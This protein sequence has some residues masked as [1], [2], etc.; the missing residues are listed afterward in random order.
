MTENTFALGSPVKIGRRVYHHYAIVSDRLHDGKPMLISL[1]YRTGSVA[2][3]P[4]DEVVRGRSVRRSDLTSKFDAGE[5]LARARARIGNTRYNLLKNNCE[6]FVRDVM[7]LPARSRQVE[8]AAGIGVTALL[9]ALRLAR[10]NPAIA[11]ASTAAG[12]LIG[13]RF[14]AK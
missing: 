6:H 11:I 9:F 2:E 7:G 14:S 3:E 10:G 1:S 13:S 8:H 5:V 12:L 4:W